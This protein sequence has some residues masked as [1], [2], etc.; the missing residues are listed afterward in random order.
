MIKKFDCLKDLFETLQ[1]DLDTALSLFASGSGSVWLLDTGI[2]LDTGYDLDSGDGGLQ[3]PHAYRDQYGDDAPKE[4]RIFLVYSLSGNE[5][6]ET[7]D[8]GDFSASEPEF[9]VRVYADKRWT[10]SGKDNFGTYM[11]LLD[12]LPDT[13]HS[14]G[15]TVSTVERVGDIDM[16]G[17]DT[18]VFYVGGLMVKER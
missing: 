1:E 6:F 10:R 4:E 12:Y 2:Y 14:Y 5:T 8:G 18:Y 13:L 17:Y 16:I 11:S 15:W 3:T 7:A 9:L